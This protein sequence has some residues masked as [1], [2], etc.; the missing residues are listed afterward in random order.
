MLGHF[1]Q[2]G[3][4]FW[5]FLVNGEYIY[6]NLY[7]HKQFNSNRCNASFRAVA[8]FAPWCIESSAQLW[9]CP[10]YEDSRK[11]QSGLKNPVYAAVLIRQKTDTGVIVA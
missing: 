3:T 9:L 10:A 2:Q 7:I 8:C 4:Y 6:I 1:G 5:S 11:K